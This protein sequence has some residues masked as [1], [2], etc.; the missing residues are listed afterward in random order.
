MTAVVAPSRKHFWTN[1]LGNQLVWVCAVSGAGHGTQWPALLSATVYVVSQL[2]SSRVPRKDAFLIILALACA[3]GVDGS[4]SASGAVRYAAA[5]WEWLPPPWILALWASFATTLTVSMAFLQRNR[6]LPI[7]FGGL[8]APVA[9]V[10]ASRGFAAVE[11]S[12]PSWIGVLILGTTWAAALSLL[13]HV[14]RRTS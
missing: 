2:L 6:W 3:F 9:Y 14:A 12:A 11:F 5:P 4:A 13:C 7:A 10:S 8:L 1:L